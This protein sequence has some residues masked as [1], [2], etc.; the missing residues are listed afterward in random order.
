MRSSLHGRLP[1]VSPGS[2]D[3]WA[4]EPTSGSSGDGSERAEEDKG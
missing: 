3:V 2:A 4:S 1:M